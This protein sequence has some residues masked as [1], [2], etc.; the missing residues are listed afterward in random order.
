MFFNASIVVIVVMGIILD[1]R[2][3][4]ALAVQWASM[5]SQLFH[6]RRK[7]YRTKQSTTILWRAQGRMTVLLLLNSC[8]SSMRLSPP[9]S[10]QELLNKWGD[11]AV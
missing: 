8:V 9:D 7:K 2:I 1:G 10:S 4:T 5:G 3:F 6:C 11:N